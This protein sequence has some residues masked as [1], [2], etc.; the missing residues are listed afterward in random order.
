[1]ATPLDLLRCLDR[2]ATAARY[3]GLS[4]RE[5]LE[6]YLTQKD[7]AAFEALLSRHGARVFAVCRQVLGD[8]EGIEDTFQATFLV[9]LDKASRIRWHDS[10]G[11]WLA[12]VAHRTAVRARAR[13]RRRSQRESQVGVETSGRARLLPSRAEGELLWREACG[14]LHEELD[15]LPDRFRLPLLLC[16]LEGHSRDEA[17]A[18]LGWSLGAVKAGLE[19]GRARLRQRLVRRG[20]TLS[21][22]LLAAVGTAVKASDPPRHL[23]QSVLRAAAGTPSPGA[24]VLV[25]GVITMTA[26]RSPRLVLG[27]M[28]TAGLCLALGAVIQQQT[29][30]E[31]LEDESSTVATMLRNDPPALDD[32]A[33]P[34]IVRGRVLNPEGKPVAGARIWRKTWSVIA[35]KWT[36]KKVATTGPDGRFEVEAPEGCLLAASAAGFAPA[37]T[38]HHP[39]DDLTLTLAHDIPIRGRLLDQRGKAVAAAKVRLRA[40]LAPL[41]GDL[42]PAYEAF[43]VNPNW[44]GDA[45]PR[46]MEG[47]MAGLPAETRTDEDGWFELKGLGRDRVAELRIE[48]PGI[49]ATRVYVCT[50]PDFDP[51]AVTP[52]PAEKKLRTIPDYQPP[53][54]GPTFTHVSGPDEVIHGTVTETRTGKPLAGVKVVGSAEPMSVTG[55]PEWSIT[56]ETSTDTRGRFRLSGLPGDRRRLLYAQAGENPYLDHVAALHNGKAPGTVEIQLRPCVVLEGRFTDRVT[57]KPVAGRALYL[58]LNDNEHLKAQRQA[59]GHPRGF[60]LFPTIG[61][62]A[63]TGSDGRFRLHM[64]PGPGVVVACAGISG[65]PPARYVAARAKAVDHKY[66]HHPDSDTGS[67][68]RSYLTKFTRMILGSPPRRSRSETRKSPQAHEVFRT[69][70]MYPLRWSHGYD[71]INP[72]VRDETA[73]CAIDADPGGTVSGKIVDP[74]GRPLAGVKAVGIH[75]PDERRATTFRTDAFTVYALDGRH[76]RPVFFVHEKRKLGGTITIRGNEPAPPIVKLV[77]WAVVTGRVLEAD[78]TPAAGAQVRFGMVDDEANDAV[79]SRLYRGR[80]VETGKDGR[81]RLEGLFP[82]WEVR[83]YANKLGRRTLG[84]FEPLLPVPGTVTDVGDT[85][86]P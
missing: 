64:F 9:L 48:A 73:T 41:S 25:S 76:P 71:I 66:L 5:L 33:E 52:T 45:L 30:R 6:C 60:G 51:R 56:V 59:G 69:A 32:S 83:V 12:A 23:L 61:T 38:T 85:R 7:Q 27:L 58:P 20:V 78:G 62:I 17:A 72:G 86:L 34:R 81:F 40:V 53:V 10:L 84:A 63:L 54:Y 2:T 65:S 70:P 57:G 15:R 49:E 46:M 77:P 67:G 55:R 35:R 8:D 74:D 50:T 24:A 21:A 11:N 19:R 18:R 1:M 36:E 13:N 31:E 4:D 3:R 44:L 79:P 14:I 26:R 22:G 39:E 75:G 80:L 43:R 29:P 42:V 47:G 82:G 28:L 37:C 16:Y 68:I